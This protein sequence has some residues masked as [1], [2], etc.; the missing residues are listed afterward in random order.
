VTLG[1]ETIERSARV[2]EI[3]FERSSPKGAVQLIIGRQVVAVQLAGLID[4]TAERVRLENELAKIA[5]DIVRIDQKLSN[6]NFV[7]RAPEEVVEEQRERRKEAENRKAKLEKAIEQLKVAAS[8]P[9][10]AA[11]RAGRQKR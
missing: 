9:N 8:T 2:S 11:R 10:P 7:E 6:K 5:D 1:R 4:F 3:K